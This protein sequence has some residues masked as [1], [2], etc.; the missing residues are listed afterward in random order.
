[1]EALDLAALAR[2]KLYYIRIYTSNPP[3]LLHWV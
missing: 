1:M 3:V 2:L